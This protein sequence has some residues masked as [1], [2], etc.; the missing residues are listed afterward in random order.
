VLYLGVTGDGALTFQNQHVAGLA[1]LPFK[2]VLSK[3]R[4]TPGSMVVL[5]VV[6]SAMGLKC[7]QEPQ[8]V[9][10][11]RFRAPASIRRPAL[12]PQAPETAAHPA[13]S[14]P[15]AEDKKPC[16]VAALPSRAEQ[17]HDSGLCSPYSDPGDAE[18]ERG[19]RAKS[20][21]EA[22]VG[23]S[24]AGTETGGA[25]SIDSLHN[26][27]LERLFG[28]V[29]TGV[30]A[31]R[32]GVAAAHHQ[33]L[34]ATATTA[35]SNQSLASSSSH[36]ASM[37]AAGPLDAMMPLSLQGAGEIREMNDS[38]SASTA[39]MTQAY[40]GTGARVD[41]NSP[42]HQK[43]K[44]LVAN[45]AY[46]P[47]AG[48]GGRGGGGGIH[49][50]PTRITGAST[51]SMQDNRDTASSRSAEHG[52]RVRSPNANCA[53]PQNHSDKRMRHDQGTSLAGPLLG[54][55]LKSLYSTAPSTSTTNA[56]N[57]APFNR[58]SRSTGPR[59]PAVPQQHT[60]LR[61]SSQ[62]PAVT[63]KKTKQRVSV[64]INANATLQKN[65]ATSAFT[66]SRR[67]PVRGFACADS[68]K[69]PSPTQARP[70]TADR[71]KT[72]SPK[73]LSRAT[74][75]ARRF[76]QTAGGEEG[77]DLVLQVCVVYVWVC[78]YVCVYVLMSC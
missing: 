11:Q 57:R 24:Q 35:N 72:V 8:T 59:K 52:K 29:A 20:P 61:H 25:I 70:K 21:H 17:S 6:D 63:A 42:Y 69:A 53:L 50:L 31:A 28:G 23:G 16:S 40:S 78:V 18:S 66:T 68:S 48:G 51:R 37:A 55:P 58:P 75:R 67:N 46:R 4:G 56:S 39:L 3:F 30:V 47:G 44:C 34:N 64:T 36:T 26:R 12:Q 27:L 9:V 33:S 73:S 54:G 41:E 2:S 10:V 14:T 77:S 7:G 76:S 43:F 65:L 38:S 22:A 60:S 19:H 49:D 13:I 15:C 71:L 62:A 32:S 5:T 45:T 1:T 74:S